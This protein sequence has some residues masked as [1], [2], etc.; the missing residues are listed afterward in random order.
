M[1]TRR[2]ISA[3]A[4]RTYPPILEFHGDG[5]ALAFR[6]R[7]RVGAV[8]QMAAHHSLFATHFGENIG[9]FAEYAVRFE[10]VRFLHFLA[11]FEILP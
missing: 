11:A 10:L 7:R 4:G 8:A 3:P 1:H 5:L 9:T 2:W 6:S